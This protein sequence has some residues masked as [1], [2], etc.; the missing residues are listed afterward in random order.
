MDLSVDFYND[1]KKFNDATENIKTIDAKIVSQ[2]VKKIRQKWGY[3]QQK[4]SYQASPKNCL[5]DIN[6][7]K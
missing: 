5:K 1:V 2:L 4:T 3:E 7:E 6:L